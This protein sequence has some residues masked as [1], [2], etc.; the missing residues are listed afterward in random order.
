MTEDEERED[1]QAAEE[2]E[3]QGFRF[4]GRE[5]E[6]AEDV[7]EQGFKFHG[8]DDEPAEDSDDSDD[9]NEVDE[10]RFSH[11]DARLKHSLATI[12]PPG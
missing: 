11:S 9:D 1:E 3:E 8:R 10:Q 5:D 2:V 7:E 12:E 4:H 6:S